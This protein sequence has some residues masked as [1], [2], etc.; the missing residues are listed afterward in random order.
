M[1]KYYFVGYTDKR[2]ET[3]HLADLLEDESIVFVSDN[4]VPTLRNEKLLKKFFFFC[5]RWN[6][7]SDG[8]PLFSKYW[9]KYYSLM[10]Y[11]FDDNDE[12]Y[13][14]FWDSA[15]SMY[16]SEA[17]FKE[18]KSHQNIKLVFYIYDQMTQVY[19]DRILRMAKYADLVYCT[20]PSD[21][22]K[23]GFKYFPLVYP[24]IN[25]NSLDTNIVNDLYFMGSD[26]GRIDDLHSIY[27]YLSDEGVICDFNIVGVDPNKCTHKG[28]TYNKKKTTKE[29]LQHTLNSNCVLEVMHEGMNAVTS[30]YPEVLALKR[31]LLTNNKNVITEPFY[32]SQYIRVFSSLEDIDVNWLK[33]KDNVDYG[34]NNDFSAKEFIKQIEK[35]DDLKKN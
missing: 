6:I 34:Y 33:K 2:V 12:H 24:E 35:C 14:I 15:I 26:G 18:L 21:C 5:H 4:L 27:D 11:D 16:Y 1:K 3:Q 8:E 20:I 9:N 29:N 23:Y 13:V 10:Q 28:I 7:I 30:R 17:F 25:I 22:K 32:N 31:K 19:S